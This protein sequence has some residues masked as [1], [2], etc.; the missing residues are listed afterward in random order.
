MYDTD[1]QYTL[2]YIKK[3]QDKVYPP[4]IYWLKKSRIFYKYPSI[5]NKVSSML[6][7]KLVTEDKCWML[8]NIL[9]INDNWQLNLEFKTDCRL[10]SLPNKKIVLF[11]LKNWFPWTFI[12]I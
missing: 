11:E 5:R 3:Q 1:S 2:N 7:K 6:T 9:S 8:T 4:D 12:T 10:K